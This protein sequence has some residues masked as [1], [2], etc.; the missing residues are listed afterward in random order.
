MWII[1]IW[2]LRIFVHFWTG[3]NINVVCISPFL[4]IF[5]L[6]IHLFTSLSWRNWGKKTCLFNFKWCLQVLIWLIVLEMEWSIFYSVHFFEINNSLTFLCLFKKS[7]VLIKTSH[8]SPVVVGVGGNLSRLC[9]RN[10]KAKSNEMQTKQKGQCVRAHSS[11]RAPHTI[12][13]N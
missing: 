3:F 4:V 11:M 1:F 2:P 5:V 13:F 12:T 6:S 10:W 7:L 8:C 9:S